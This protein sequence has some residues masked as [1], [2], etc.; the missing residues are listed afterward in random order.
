MNTKIIK[1]IP[2]TSKAF[3]KIRFWLRD[4]IGPQHQVAFSDDELNDFSN[5]AKFQ[6]QG[7]VL[8]VR[9]NESHTAGEAIVRIEDDTQAV[10]FYLVAHDFV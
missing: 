5:T 9:I 4:N 10:M 3:D 7:W 2:F 8:F 1:N 6:G